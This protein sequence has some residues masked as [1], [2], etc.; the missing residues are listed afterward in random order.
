MRAARPIG[1]TVGSILVLLRSGAWLSAGIDLTTHFAITMVPGATVD[2]ATGQ[3]EFNGQVISEPVAV[4]IVIVLI[5][6]IL[7]VTVV[8]IV[9]TVSV[10]RGHNFSRL[11]VMLF[12]TITIATAIFAYTASLGLDLR[13]GLF[14]F[15]LD[16]GVLLALSGDDAQRFA[17]ARGQER[18][19]AKLQRRESGPSKTQTPVQSNRAGEP[20]E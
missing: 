10:Y 6:A 20:K 17:R 11:I 3:V 1:T 13:G 16:I 14:A 2:A 5:L 4:I 19:I 8:P 12:S 9:L 7:L 15:S 18:R